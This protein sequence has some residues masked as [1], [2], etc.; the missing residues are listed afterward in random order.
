MV[1]DTKEKLIYVLSLEI[2]F[3]NNM[4][5]LASFKKKVSNIFSLNNIEQTQFH[6]RF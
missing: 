6:S 1:H 5:I 4:Q 3:L 2:S